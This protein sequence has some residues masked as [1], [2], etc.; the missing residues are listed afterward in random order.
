M[1]KLKDTYLFFKKFVCFVLDVD[2]LTRSQ[3]VAIIQQKKKMI[4]FKI[5][6]LWCSLATLRM[7]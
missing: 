4:K 2:V 6:D 3:Y 1:D 7:A 5:D